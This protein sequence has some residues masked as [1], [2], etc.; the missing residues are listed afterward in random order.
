[1][2]VLH[3]RIAKLTFMFLRLLIILLSRFFL[4]LRSAI[5]DREETLATASDIRFSADHGFGGSVIFGAEE[6]NGAPWAEEVDE[7]HQ[8]FGRS[9]C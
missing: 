3:E 6:L 4:N 2:S 7:D 8:K 9:R 5:D 1:M